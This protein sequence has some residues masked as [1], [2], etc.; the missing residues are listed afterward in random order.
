[1]VKVAGGRGPASQCEF[2]NPYHILCSPCETDW[3]FWFG[4]GRVY[5]SLPLFRSE[6]ASILL[7]FTNLY[8]RGEGL[9]IDLGVGDSV[10]GWASVARV[11]H[12]ENGLNSQKAIDTIAEG[13]E[14]KKKK[15]SDH[16]HIAFYEHGGKT[17]MAMLKYPHI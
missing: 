7:T 2:T 16:G 12:S 15:K 14:K 1:M 8:H 13:V 10:L 4:R 11:I 6:S 3:C 9:G 5:Q 17:G